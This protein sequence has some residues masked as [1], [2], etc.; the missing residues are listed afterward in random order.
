MF[1]GFLYS[2]YLAMVVVDHRPVIS[3]AL[4]I[5]DYNNVPFGHPVMV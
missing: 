5:P 2:H 3:I 4:G 1:T